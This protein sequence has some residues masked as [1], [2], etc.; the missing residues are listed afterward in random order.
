MKKI[1]K[2]SL[3]SAL[4]VASRGL[5][6]AQ[7]NDDDD[8]DLVRKIEVYGNAER[9]ITPNEIFFS[10]TL[11]EY[12]NDGKNK[13]TID[14][15]ERELYSAV[16]KVGVSDEDFQVQDV[17]GYNYDWYWRGRKKEREEFLATKQ[18]RV[19]FKDLNEINRLFAYVDAKGIQS[20]N[21]EGY[22]HSDIEEIRKELK[23][24][25]L[26]NAKDKADY[27]LDGIKEGL[28]EIIEVQEINVDYQPPIYYAKTMEMAQSADMMEQPQID[29]KKIKLQAQVRAVFRI[30]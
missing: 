16:R 24:E 1:L 12:L 8:H 20:S 6:H 13:V 3:L 15:L 18:Y 14:E 28:G 30:R 9:E 29:F 10:I 22:S 19:K 17:A 11:K 25:A 23:I 26:K 21:V 5:V 27:L 2:I 7:N 4:L